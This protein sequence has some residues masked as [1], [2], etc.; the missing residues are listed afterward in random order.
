MGKVAAMGWL[1]RLSFGRGGTALAEAEREDADST[2]QTTGPQLMVLV[3]DASGRASFKTHVFDDVE[4]AIEWVRYWFP[5]DAE[6]GMTAFWAMTDRPESGPDSVAEPLVMIRDTSRDGVVYLF[7]F[8]DIDSAQAFLREEV[9]RGT[10]PDAMLFYWAVQV[11]REIDRWGKLTLTPS[12]PPGVAAFEPEAEAAENSW[13][14]REAPVAERAPA[15]PA[16]NARAL[17]EEAPNARTGVTEVNDPGNETFELTSWI[18]RARKS[19][20]RQRDVVEIAAEVVTASEESFKTAAVEA[21]PEVFFDERVVAEAALEE[22]EAGAA[23][24]A[25]PE[26][27]DVEPEPVVSTVKAVEETETDVVTETVAF[28]DAPEAMEAEVEAE[29]FTDAPEL[30]EPVDDVEVAAV[31]EA[32]E[33]TE[34]RTP[35]EAVSETERP[36]LDDRTLRARAGTNGNGHK[37]PLAH[38]VVVEING[39]KGN[40]EARAE[41]SGSESPGADE[42]RT[43]VLK[44]TLPSMNGNAAANGHAADVTSQ[45]GEGTSAIERLEDHSDAEADD[46]ADQTPEIVHEVRVDAAS[47]GRDET[48]S[49]QI[50]IHLQSRA[51]R[52]KRWEVKDEPFEGFKSPPGRF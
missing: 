52:M 30:P 47:N 3:N 7:S 22:A 21:E 26:A 24:E 29:A 16:G 34:D 20:S 33:D 25:A 19:P 4:A 51:L 5:M 39:Y 32:S 8:V 43:Y 41:S 17:M 12:T 31:D 10:K 18:E 28:V 2:P 15:K 42:L 11:K 23:V 37:P 49:I 38:E 36:D 46:T 6:I 48:I 40:H 45:D 1:A 27:L 50:A 35:I 9:E 14:V 13:I 44:E